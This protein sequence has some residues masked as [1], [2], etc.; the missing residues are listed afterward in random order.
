MKQTRILVLGAAAVAGAAG[1]GCGSLPSPDLFARDDVKALVAARG[2]PV[3]LRLG[4]AGLSPASAPSEGTAG[5]MA[6]RVGV[7]TDLVRDEVGAA[8][9]RSGLF[10]DV[11]VLRDVDAASKPSDAAAAADRSGLDLVLTVTPG[12]QKVAYTGRSGSVYL[13][14]PI[15][16]LFGWPSVFV[17][18]E[19]FAMES[20][21]TVSVLEAR[22]GKPL[23]DSE[24]RGKVEY[25]LSDLQ[26]GLNFWSDAV[27]GLSMVAHSSFVGEANFKAAAET[28]GVHARNEATA[29][30]LKQVSGPLRQGLTSGTYAEVLGAAPARIYAVVAGAGRYVAKADEIPP[31]KQAEGDAKAVWDWLVSSGGPGMREDDGTLLLGKDA[32]RAKVLDA[33]KKVAARRPRENDVVLVHVATYGAAEDRPGAKKEDPREPVLYLYDSDVNS[34]MGTGLPVAEI[35]KALSGVPGTVVLLIDAGFGV[36]T[37]ARSLGARGEAGTPVGAPAAAASRP[38]FVVILGS[39]RDGE[40]GDDEDSGHG[41]FTGALLKGLAGAADGNRDGK[42]TVAEVLDHAVSEVET[43]ASVSGANQ[44]PELLC[45]DPGRAVFPPKPVSHGGGRGN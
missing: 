39:G 21:Y 15:W 5:P 4:V 9:K 11:Q 35:E 19:N 3:P 33:L 36:K 42:I 24:L 38:G 16:L 20:A 27:L 1:A 25:A 6:W 41:A 29:N 17:A 30:L 23:W 7:K 8:L 34:L 10:A 2:Q 28:L 22:T 45:G 14:I 31:L 37:G 13:N 12:E 18:D 40:A 32:T 44:K 43:W 26:R